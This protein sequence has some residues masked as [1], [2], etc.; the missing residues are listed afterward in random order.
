MAKERRVRE[1]LEKIN[2][3]G[4]AKKSIGIFSV[5]AFSLAVTLVTTAVLARALG[6]AGQGAFSL[7]T[8][9]PWI[10]VETGNLGIGTAI[11][12]FIGKEK[13]G[14]KDVVNSIW[15]FDL[16]WGSAITII[17]LV[18]LPFVHPIF[19]KGV[20]L[21]YIIL[22][23]VVF[24]IWL[25]SQHLAWVMLAKEDIVKYN[26]LIAIRP[27]AFIF[28]LLISLLLVQ[29]RVLGAII[30]WDLA[31]VLN[32]IIAVFYLLK[33]V[34]FRLS[35]DSGLIKNMLSY[36][37]K[38]YMGS[39]LLFFNYRFD[40][41]LVS[42]FLSNTQ[43][44]F[45][46]VALALAEII[47]RIPN[48]IG[49]ALFPRVSS[50]KAED[51]N[52]LTPLVARNTVFVAVL[53]CLPFA[54]FGKP[55]VAMVLGPS[56][57]PLFSALWL[58]MPGVV[59]FSAGRILISHF[60]GS[61]RPMVSGF[62]SLVSL[63]VMVSLDMFFIPRWGIAGAALASTIAYTVFSLIMLWFFVRGMNISLRE[64]LFIRFSDL[65]AYSSLGSRGFNAGRNLLRRY[66]SGA[67]AK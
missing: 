43:V 38:A 33:L 52:L 47:W 56:F 9:V 41:L 25:L 63:I 34:P 10:L 8:L 53:A 40:L 60:N 19:F 46:S 17:A 65:Q 54:I 13:Y 36:G 42:M 1:R 14:F 31:I 48:S 49:L 23:L 67:G 45:Y 7:I 44:G 37:L 39:V 51:N 2:T 15:V 29:N 32:A 57:L 35:F 16:L 55:L 20:D 66:L 50:S 61:G 59:I 22:S 30:S 12:Y 3:G 62:S 4:L 28:L 21:M 64:L 18:A 6:P 27:L 26:V 5:Q 11:V 58:L 24:P